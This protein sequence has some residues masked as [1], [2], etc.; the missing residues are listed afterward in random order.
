MHTP[1]PRH[2]PKPSHRQQTRLLRSRTQLLRATA[3]LS[4]RHFRCH[5][6]LDPTLNQ[7]FHRLI[8]PWQEA[9]FTALDPAWIAL[10][11]RQPPHQSARP[12]LKRAWIERPRGHAKTGDIAIQIAWALLFT[13]RA[14]RGVAVAADREQAALIVDAVRRLAQ[15]NLT[16]CNPLRLHRNVIENPYCGAR[17]EIISADVASSFGLTPDFVVCDELCHWQDERLWH[18]LA[19]SAAKKPHCLL[20]VLTN[21]G[22]GRGWQWQARETAR[23]RNDWYFSTFDGPR[24]PWIRDEELAEQR[25]ILPPNVYDRLWNNHWQ[26]AD[27]DY[28]TGIEIAACRDESWY[29]QS[30]GRPDRHYV[31]AIDYAE[32]HNLTAAVVLHREGEHLLID[33][34]DVAVPQP[35]AP[36]L[37]TWVEQWMAQ[38]A[39]AFPQLTFVIDDYQLLGTLQRLSRRHRVVRFPFAGGKGNH[40]LA[41]TLRR[42]IV[43]RQLRW[44]RGCGARPDNPRDDLEAELGAL[45]LK[46]AEAG[47]LR[48]ASPPRGHDD[49]AFVVAAAAWQALR[50]PSHAT[51]WKITPPHRGLLNW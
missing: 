22:A 33:R 10:A 51:L 43:H 17:L 44:Y 46:Q 40:E 26:L 42:L 2:T 9:D 16:L 4:P 21:A 18:S 14:L 30:R 39:A 25:A 6:R 12:Y 24:A 41:L 49:R 37:V 13:R 48:F 36:V 28:L 19:S 11:A 47:R 32:K 5:L 27:G 7:P 34:L 35:D 23:T 31:A 38:T 29:E 1:R 20:I 8:Q 45:V 3:A 50:E 15:A